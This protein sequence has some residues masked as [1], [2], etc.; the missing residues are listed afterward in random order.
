MDSNKNGSDWMD[1]KKPISPGPAW[2][3]STATIGTAAKL[4]C[5][6]DWANRFDHAKRWKEGDKDSDMQGL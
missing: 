2:S 3:K 6:A 4:S 5:S 1:A